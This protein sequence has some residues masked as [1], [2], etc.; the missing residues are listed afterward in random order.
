MLATDALKEM[1]LNGASTAELKSE[2]I[3]LGMRTL[4]QSA[5][6]KMVEGVTTCDE[7]VRI[8]ASD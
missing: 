2:A 6:N 1:I 4:R 3:R 5:V 7:V 8:S